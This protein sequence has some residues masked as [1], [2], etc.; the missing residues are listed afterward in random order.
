MKIAHHI[1][2]VLTLVVF[3][4]CSTQK[5]EEPSEKM[6]L[7]GR[8]EFEWERLKDPATGKVPENIRKTPTKEA[9]IN[10]MGTINFL[11]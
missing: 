6:G 4:A 5:T 3:S 9:V 1:F 10:N 11:I 8:L 2:F 7:S